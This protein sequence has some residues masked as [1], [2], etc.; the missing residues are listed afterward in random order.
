VE[1]SNVDCLC[2][3]SSFM[4]DLSSCRPVVLRARAAAADTPAG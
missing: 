3:G 4:A 2:V 1:V